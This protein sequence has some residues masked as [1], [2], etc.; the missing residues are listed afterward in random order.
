MRLYFKR[1]F[2]LDKKDLSAKRI[3]SAMLRRIVNI[4]Y[5]LLWYYPF[6]FSKT[7][8]SRIKL[9]KDKHIGKRCFIVANGP[10]LKN[11]DMSLLKNEYT[12]GMNRIYLMES[13]NGFSPT[14]LFCVDKKTQLQQF[15]DDYDGYGDICFYNFD[16]KNF[17]SRKKNQIF[18][19]N[20]Y[21][22]RF[23][24]DPLIKPL[25][26]G[27]SVTYSC[28]QMAYYMGFSEVYIIGKDHSYNT[29]ENAGETVK[30]DG[31]EQNHFIQ[32]YYKPGMIWGS[33]DYISEEYSY[34]LA[35]EYYENN[36]RIIK[37]ATLG[38]Q[39]NV[40]EKVDYYSLFDK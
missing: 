29:K 34:L 6:G 17:F 30:S 27:Q 5:L 39:L 10:S 36:G 23:S 15:R 22:P 13:V 18:I 12:I 9:Y 28:I 38:G 26:D 11:I 21:T 14:Y 19:K 7:N 16:S 2:V 37:D 1:L 4:Y 8:K 33:P 31:K 24:D 35:K 40:F 25:G 32:G 20:G 3:F